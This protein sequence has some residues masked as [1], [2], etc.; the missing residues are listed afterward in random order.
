MN[1][2]VWAAALPRQQ[3]EVNDWNRFQKAGGKAAVT[4]HLKSSCR[5]KV[6]RREGERELVLVSLEIIAS[7]FSREKQK[8][9]ENWVYIKVLQR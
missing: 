5:R 8:K 9:V 2:K 3:H 4:Y 6:G 1:K 7:H